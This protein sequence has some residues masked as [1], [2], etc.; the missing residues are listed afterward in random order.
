MRQGQKVVAGERIAALGN[1]GNSTG[2]HLHFHVTDGVSFGSE[3]ISCVFAGY[4]DLGQLGVSLD[5]LEKG[6]VA[7]VGTPVQKTDDLPLAVAS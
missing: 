2:P 4:A 1:S 5:D 6:K 7:A 3:A